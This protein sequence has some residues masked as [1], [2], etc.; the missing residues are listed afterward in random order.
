[1]RSS[2]AFLG[3][4]CA[5]TAFAQNFWD[6]SSVTV[7]ATAL[8]PLTGYK[9]TQVDPGAGISLQYGFR[10]SHYLAAEGGI[11]TAWPSDVTNCSK[12][13]CM[14]ERSAARFTPFGL[15]GILPLKQ[16][17]VQLTAGF[18]GAYVFRGNTDRSNAEQWLAQVSVGFSVAFTREGSLRL[19]PSVRF[20]SDLGRPTQ[21]WTA[22]SLELIWSPRF[23][24]D[25]RVVRHSRR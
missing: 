21:K 2:F 5:S 25:A 23:L 15:R 10:L 3:L 7:A 18:G 22:T 20:Y 1:M 4:I 13:G 9:L 6:R 12:F 24:R 17:R 16:D 14:F 11:Q 19:G 8:S